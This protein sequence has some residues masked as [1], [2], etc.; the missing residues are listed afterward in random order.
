MEKCGKNYGGATGN[1]NGE[2]TGLLNQTREVHAPN[3]ETEAYIVHTYVVYNFSRDQMH[4]LSLI[5]TT[6]LSVEI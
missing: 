6:Q 1:G 2:Y 5:F 3:S 4:C